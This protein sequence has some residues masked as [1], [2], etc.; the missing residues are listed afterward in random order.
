MLYV[1]TRNKQDSYTAHRALLENYAPDGGMFVPLHFAT[2]T[3]DEIAVLKEKSFS[4]NVAFVLNL[5]F[6]RQLNSWDVEFSIG[7]YPFRLAMLNQ[8][9]VI[10]ELWH[11]IENCYDHL[12]ESLYQKLTDGDTDSGKPTQ[13]VKIAVEIAVIFGLYGELQKQG[14][15]TIDMAV[16]ADDFLYP[17][18]AWYARKM[19]LPINCIICGCNRNEKLWDFLQRGEFDHSQSGAAKTDGVENICIERLLFGTLGQ[20]GVLAYLD[21][22]QA[23]RTFLLNEDELPVFNDG[24][25]ASVIGN[26]RTGTVINSIYRT[27]TYITEPVTAIS[28][29]AL[30]DYRAKTGENRQTLILA[31]QT[32][33]LFAEQIASAIGITQEKVNAMIRLPKE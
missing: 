25:F 29:A 31:R 33:A 10:A 5:L 21:A 24:F 20:S 7:R 14:L 26:N 27:N 12:V 19:G 13:W 9:I 22:N 32:P 15:E 11:N 3:P 23:G 1:S 6:S 17:I 28:Y 30:Q 18:S 8:R 2:L 4:E 16:T